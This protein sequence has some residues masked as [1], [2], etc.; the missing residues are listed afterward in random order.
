MI[1][2]LMHLALTFSTSLGIFRAFGHGAECLADVGS[3]LVRVPLR[4]L[5]AVAGLIMADDQDDRK[6]GPF[7]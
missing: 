4:H 2:R 6:Q 5:A 3:G 7:G 1:S